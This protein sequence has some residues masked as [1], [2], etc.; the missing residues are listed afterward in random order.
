[1]PGEPVTIA[2]PLEDD[3]L[4]RSSHYRLGWFVRNDIYTAEIANA[5]VHI[6]SGIVC[7]RSFRLVTE[8]GFENR[9]N[10]V[11]EAM[12]FRKCRPR[13]MHGLHS[14]INHI[15]A[16]NFGH[17]MID[18][19]PRIITLE[20]A[21][22]FRPIKFLMPKD[23]SEFQRETLNII[24]PPHFSVEYLDGD[25]WARLERLVWASPASGVENFMLPPQ[26]FQSIRSRVFAR[27]GLSSVHQMKKRIYISRRHAKHRRIRNELAVLALLSKYGFEDVELETLPF[28]KQVEMFHQCEILVATHGAGE[29]TS[30]FSGPI[31]IV[32][33]YATETPPNYFHTQ[34]KGLGQSH[35]YICGKSQSDDDDFDVDVEELR[36]K[37][38]GILA[39]DG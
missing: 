14:T 20:I 27:Y 30:M 2:S 1:M 18:C 10:N 7:D 16:R 5:I 8:H 26:Y 17:W 39:N 12:N 21:Y 31:S 15:Y 29:C 24:L 34:A 11:A 28:Q 35:S 25:L 37:L 22:P 3:F 38:D 4:L 6:G 32:L 13:L 19:I 33:L 23:A 9:H 36:K